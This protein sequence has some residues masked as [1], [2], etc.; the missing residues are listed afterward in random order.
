M[1]TYDLVQ[2]V[3]DHAGFHVAD[4]WPSL[5]HRLSGGTAPTPRRGSTDFSALSCCAMGMSAS[6]VKLTI[7]WDDTSLVTHRS[8]CMASTDSIGQ[9]INQTDITEQATIGL[10]ICALPSLCPGNRITRVSQIGSRAD[11]YLNGRSTEMIEIGG[12]NAGATTIGTL[13]NQKRAQILQGIAQD[14]WVL[15]ASF[16]TAE[17]RLEKVR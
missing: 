9:T 6:A 8:D 1:P 17:T 12:T 4:F 2:S 15:V 14:A 3:V 11:Y 7:C 13:F 5:L 16:A 10:T